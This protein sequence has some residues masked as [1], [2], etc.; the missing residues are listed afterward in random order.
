MS[1]D[2]GQLVEDRPAPVVLAIGDPQARALGA[3]RHHGCL[4]TDVSARMSQHASHAVDW[5]TGFRLVRAGSCDGSVNRARPPTLRAPR[6][7]EAANRPICSSMTRRSRGLM[8]SRRQAV[9][10]IG[11]KAMSCSPPNCG[12]R[13]WR[14]LVQRRPPMAN[15]YRG[16]CVATVTCSR[17]WTE[18]AAVAGDVVMRRASPDMRRTCNRVPRNDARSGQRAR[19]RPGREPRPGTPRTRPAPGD[20]RPGIA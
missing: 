18:A 14:L 1:I 6:D 4:R 15:F 16:R 3:G 10:P 8:W 9:S 17:E 20:P 7:S 13:D 12:R 5:S 2:R 11:G 19:C